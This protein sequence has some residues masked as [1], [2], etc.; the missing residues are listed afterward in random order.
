[1]KIQVG[2][3]KTTP[4]WEE[5]LVQEGVPFGVIEKGGWPSLEEY[6]VAIINRRITSD[7]NTNVREYLRN[8]G[9]VLTR[10]DYAEGLGGMSVRPENIEYIFGDNIFPIGLTDISRE[11]FVVSEANCLRTEKNAHTAFVGD[12]SGGYAVLLPFDIAEVTEDCRAGERTFYAHRERLPSERVSAV[13]KGNVRLLLHQCLEHLHHVRHMPYAHLSYFPDNQSNIFAFRI[14]SDG[15]SQEEVNELYAIGQEFEIPISW[16]LDAKS[17]EQW[18]ARFAEMEGQEIGVHCYDHRT[19]DD[20]ERIRKDIEHAATLLE[21][22]GIR[23]SGFSAPYGVWSPPLAQVL[24][25]LEFEY[26]SEFSYAYD[27]LPLRPSFQGRRFETLQVPIHPICIGSLLKIGYSPQDQKR[28]F[29]SIIKAKRQ[30]PEPLF[31]YHHPSHMHWGVV[32]DLFET[33]RNENIRCMSLGEY[34]A[35]WKR[36]TLVRMSLEIMEDKIVIRSSDT[37]PDDIRLR[38][39]REDKTEAIAPMSSP[40]KLQSLNWT[41]TSPAPALPDDFRRIK[42][43]DLRQSVGKLF[44]R[45]QRDFQ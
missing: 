39:T 25:E 40:L 10:A 41:P 33:M 20:A 37:L 27:T 22:I 16:Y 12:F 21:E 35:W 13:S 11:G 6:S 45:L 42:E 19:Y 34:A 8:G 24:D 7:E 43:F 18:L 14:D 31:F 1:M 26:S 9:A 23:R 3:L 2:L 5:L 17:H 44:T 32:R 30:Q 38:V 15:A 4:M 28:Y 36:R 29:A